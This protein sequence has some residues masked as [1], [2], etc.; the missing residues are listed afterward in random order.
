M[1]PADMLQSLDLKP[2]TLSVYLGALSDAG[3]VHSTREG[4]RLFYRANL[5]AMGSLVDY[6]VADCCRGRPDLCAT[7]TSAI[8]ANGGKA[9]TDK[10]Y[11]VLFICTGNSARSIFAEALLRDIGGDRFKVY[12]AGTQPQSE[13]NPF[14][15]EVLHR[16]GHTTDELR[17]KHISEFQAADAPAL[18]FV[19]T[20]CD[21]AASE[22]CP[23]WSGQPI[24]AHWGLKDPVKVTG[25][26]A[27]KAYAFADTYAQMRRRVMAFSSLPFGSLDRISLQERVDDIGASESA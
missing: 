14:A 26:D 23:A 25:T 7:K 4:T 17:S 10:T 21:T 19:F 24:S 8:F 16:N 27:E 20:V 12:S 18:D 3:L 5:T 9:M 2:N 6:L 22:E 1:R 11:S 15:I 13:L